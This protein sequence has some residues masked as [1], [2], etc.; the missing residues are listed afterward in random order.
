MN[1]KTR[2]RSEVLSH[3]TAQYDKALDGVISGKLPPTYMTKRWGKLKP[4]LPKRKHHK[5][6]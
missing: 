4:V 1:R 6:L 5:S 3:R 2:K